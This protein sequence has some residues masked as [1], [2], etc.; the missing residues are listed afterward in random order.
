M[1]AFDIPEQQ[2]CVY[3]EDPG[4]TWHHRILLLPLGLAGRWIACSSDYDV[5]VVDLVILIRYH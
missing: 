5:E 2:V 4:Q 3:F 1:N